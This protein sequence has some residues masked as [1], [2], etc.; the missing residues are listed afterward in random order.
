MVVRRDHF[1]AVTRKA[2]RISSRSMSSVS[3]GRT[4]VKGVPVVHHEDLPSLVHSN[5]AAFCHLCH[6]VSSTCRALA[7]HAVMHPGHTGS[8]SQR[9][10]KRAQEAITGRYA[11]ETFRYP[12]RLARVPAS[13]SFRLCAFPPHVCRR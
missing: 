7:S 11:P 13:G 9:K 6:E 5:V 3:Y 4:G 1:A 10:R 12:G 8:P 2:T